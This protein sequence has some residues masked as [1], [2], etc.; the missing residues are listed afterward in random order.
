MIEVRSNDCQFALKPTWFGL[1]LMFREA[2]LANGYGDWE[3][4][5]WRK[6]TWK[7]MMRFNK[8]RLR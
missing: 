3:W 2:V 4:G 8:E 5:R 1:V 7:D 6:A